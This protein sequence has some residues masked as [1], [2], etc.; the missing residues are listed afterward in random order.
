MKSD[1]VDLIVTVMW[2]SIAAICGTFTRIVLAQLFGE[3][4]ANPGTV[5]WLAAG[6]PLCVTAGGE[7]D[8]QGGIVY[9]VRAKMPSN[10]TSGLLRCTSNIHSTQ[11]YS[12]FLSPAMINV[13]AGFTGQLV[14]ILHYGTYA[15]YHCPRLAH[16][17]SHCMDHTRFY[18]SALGHFTLG[19]SS[20]LLRFP[21]HLFKLELG[22]D[23]HHVRNRLIG[24]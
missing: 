1:T 9:A 22:N 15:K 21:H 10:G 18:V 3:E 16:G 23:H 20:W 24:P 2:I 7:A 6:S 14:G 17:Q 19:H 12:S 4:C 8:Q 11:V 13:F 5:G